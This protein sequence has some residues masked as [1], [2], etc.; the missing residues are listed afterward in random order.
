MDAMKGWIMPDEMWVVGVVVLWVLLQVWI[1]P[2][3]GVST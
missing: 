2:S 3:I 1:L